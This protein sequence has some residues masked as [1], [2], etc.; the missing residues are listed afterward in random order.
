[1]E[2]GRFIGP[3]S[4]SDQGNVKALILPELVQ[5][6]SEAGQSDEGAQIADDFAKRA[7]TSD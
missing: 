6:L 1:M 7:Q 2:S 4:V 3:V 5:M